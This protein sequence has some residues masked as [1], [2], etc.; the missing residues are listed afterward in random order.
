MLYGK[1]KM[2]E[3]ELTVVLLFKLY[4]DANAEALAAV[5]DV[6]KLVVEIVPAKMLFLH[7]KVPAPAVEAPKFALASVVVPSIN[8][9]SSKSKNTEL[10]TFY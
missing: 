9:P 2:F 4:H 10:Y 8:N 5:V 7:F 6:T 3:L 1:L